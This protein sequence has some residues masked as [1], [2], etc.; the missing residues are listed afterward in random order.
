MRS[1]R[2]NR[3]GPGAGARSR[4]TGTPSQDCRRTRHRA[5]MTRSRTFPQ[6]S[7]PPRSSHPVPCCP[8]RRTT[9][10]GLGAVAEPRPGGPA[11]SASTVGYD[12]Q[13]VTL[14]AFHG[15]Y[16]GGV[17][18]GQ[19]LSPAPAHHRRNGAVPWKLLTEAGHSVV[20]ATET[21]ATPA[22]NPLL[23]M[24]VCSASSARGP[25]RSRFIANSRRPPRSSRRSGGASAAL[26]T[27]LQ[28]LRDTATGKFLPH[29]CITM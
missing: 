16:T 1:Y 15:W 12:V 19:S 6:V 10:P 29:A 11:R 24:G 3:A 27:A 9:A 8:T 22:C 2:A 14:I 5:P 13:R 7:W 25:S 26:N 20:F 23:L 17:L 28:N 21:G 18:S 4:S